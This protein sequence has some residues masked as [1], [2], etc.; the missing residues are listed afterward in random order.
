MPYS[1]GQEQ[2]LA[3]LAETIIDAFES[4]ARGARGALGQP[5]GYVDELLP[6]N[7]QQNL[8]RIRN[9][10]R[11]S[12][13]TLCLEPAIA[14]VEVR[15]PDTDTPERIYISRGSSAG[16]LPQDLVGKLVSY[17]APLGRLAEIP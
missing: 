16:M 4:I 6:P 12:L 5:S 1:S 9:D 14:R 13:S 17:R 3:K 10:V 7:A 11:T 2:V 8:Q 15:W